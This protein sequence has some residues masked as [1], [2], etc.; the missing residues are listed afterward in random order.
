MKPKLLYFYPNR[1]TFI[2]KDIA[3]L[4]EKY[5]IQTQ[6]LPWT[7][8]I[9]LP[10]NFIKQF[11]F[12]IS[13]INNTRVILVMFG[14]YWSFLPALIGK[15]FRKK[16]FIILGGTDCV[17]FPEFNYGSLR[18][19]PLTWFIK[20][21][22]QWCTRLLTVDDS[23]M[24]VDYNFLKNATYKKQGV[25]AY[26]PNLKTPYTVIPN[27]FD[28]AFWKQ[29]ENNKTPHS[30]LSIAFVNDTTRLTLKG[31]DTVIAL[32]NHF[33]EASFTLVG[34]SKTFALKLKLPKNIKIYAYLSAKELKKEIEK[35]RFY[36]QL[37]LSE[38]FPNALAEAMLGQCIP[39]VT[40][41]GGM[42]KIVKNTGIVLAQE[43]KAVLIEEINKLLALPQ[44]NLE[45]MGA[46]ARS[47]IV[48]NFSIEKRA[49]LL[50]STLSE[51]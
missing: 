17:Y 44:S 15:L 22:Y 31:F 13:R 2:E 18:K 51:V 48:S 9:S 21:S 4:S 19:Q 8:K 36:L 24:Y 43:N 3:S 42:P 32:A 29:K 35:H 20:K 12:L 50:V 25:K 34:L 16:V 10:V 11:F 6:D 38:G 27:G 33:K 46:S 23:L 45:V 5:D 26:F 14:G 30:F 37:S 1:A 40:A 7:D 39:I 41:V 49:A 28:A 47:Q